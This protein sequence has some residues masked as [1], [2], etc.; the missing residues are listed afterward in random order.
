MKIYKKIFVVMLSLVLSVSF[1]GCGKTEETGT[2]DPI[3]EEKL[4]DT[5]FVKD[6]VSE[7]KFVL[8][9]KSEYSGQIVYS[10]NLLNFA[11]TEF[12]DLVKEITGAEIQLIDDS[13]I[14]DFNGKY[15]SVGP[16]KIFKNAG[17]S[18]DANKLGLD[19]FILKTK[20]DAVIINGG[21]DYGSLY[22]VYT[23]LQKMFGL[24]FFTPDCYTFNK[25][26]NQKIYDFNTT[27]IPDIPT[28]VIGRYSTWYKD[29][30]SMCRMRCVNAEQ[31]M[32]YLGHAFI[33][34][35]PHETYYSSHPEW[36][37]SEQ[38]TCWDWQLCMTKEDLKEEFTKNVIDYVETNPNI[39]IISLGQNDNWNCCYCSD[40]LK[41]M[42]NYGG[43]NNGGEAGLYI[44]FANDVVTSVMEHFNKEDPERAKQLKF[45][46]FAYYYTEQ[47]PVKTKG[48]K[49][50]PYIT[51][52]D[53]LG[54]FYAPLRSHSSHAYLDE[55]N[56]ISSK[57]L[58]QWRE[59]VK[60]IYVWAYSVDFSDYFVPFNCYGSIKQNIVDYVSMGAQFV[61]DQ[62]NCGNPCS[63]FEELKTYLISKLM[64][65]SKL[66]FDSLVKNFMKVYY[67]DVAYSYIYKYWDILRTH[68]ASLEKT[69]GSY[70]F[71]YN[72]RSVFLTPSNMPKDL[73]LFFKGIFQ[74]AFNE[75]KS[76]EDQ[77]LYN[78]Y[79]S[80]LEKEYL[81]VIY[82]MM[83]VNPSSGS[84]SSYAR[85]FERICDEWNIYALN[86]GG[87]YNI[88]SLLSK[89]R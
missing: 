7:Y 64:W 35:L 10:D 45:Y 37:T 85:E 19:G 41:E 80:R 23:F 57:A 18:F 75:L 38:S 58:S 3:I 51:P 83:I 55:T 60:D 56:T 76:I 26:L 39:N 71:Y 65:N 67:G 30:K 84:I 6:G 34:I 59:I 50:V 49:F 73:I 32:S 27:D 66:D 54:I 89:F 11:F 2:D 16:T 20:G 43:R 87:S 44:K 86:E 82:M 46:I 72:N 70:M 33:Y 88:N 14:I 17:F 69:T 9:S 68:L 63:D 42:S 40:C 29:F 62:G 61:F 78:L 12:H 74:D 48:D 81:E 79:K 15:I 8:P 47:A 53:N 5:Y 52:V 22:G 25:T 28:R 36:Y 77:N 31:R 4:L 13:S 1:L 21:S 24:E